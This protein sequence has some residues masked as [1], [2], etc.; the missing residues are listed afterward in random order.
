[1][2]NILK[3][4]WEAYFDSNVKMGYMNKEQVE[5]LKMIIDLRELEKEANGKGMM[6]NDN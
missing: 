3:D 1:M 5:R 2:N 6:V 4:M